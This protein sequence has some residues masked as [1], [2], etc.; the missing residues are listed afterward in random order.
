[1]VSQKLTSVSQTR[2]Q[3]IQEARQVE[4]EGR[5]QEARLLV[6]SVPHLSLGAALQIGQ[7]LY[8]LQDWLDGRQRRM[9]ARRKAMELAPGMADP[10]RDWLEMMGA[11]EL[12]LLRLGCSTVVGSLHA[13]NRYELHLRKRSGSLKMCKKLQVG[14][15]FRLVD[16]AKWESVKSVRPELAGA[17]LRQPEQ[18]QMRRPFPQKDLD[19]HRAQRIRVLLMNGLEWLGFVS[20]EDAYSLLLTL[21]LNSGPEMLI[22]KTAVW[23]IGSG[24]PDV[25]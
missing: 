12:M 8:S 25:S 11:Q 18:P 14:C 22:Y 20:W 2:R 7:G 15:L 9:E 21:E 10:A 17:Q 4:F 23:S 5:M 19:R 24:G 3:R 13:Q 16:A 6:Q 1:M